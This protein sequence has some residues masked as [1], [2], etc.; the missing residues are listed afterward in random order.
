MFSEKLLHRFSL[1][2]TRPIDIKPDGIALQPSIE[3]P[4]HLE[5]SLPITFACLNH[6][7]ATQ[8]RGHPSR[9]VQPQ[10]MLACG[11]NAQALPPFSPTPTQSRMQAKARLV[12]ENYRLPLSQRLKFFLKAYGISGPP[13]FSLAD[14]CNR[15]ASADIPGDA[16]TSG[17]AL[18]LRLSRSAA[19]SGSPKSAHPIALDSAQSLAATSPGAPQW[20]SA[21]WPLNQWACQASASVVKPANPLDSPHGS[22]GSNSSAL[23]PRLPLS[24]LDADPLRPRATRLSLFLPKPQGF[25]RPTLKD[26]LSSPQ[27]ESK[28]K[29]GSSCNQ[30]SIVVAI[31]NFI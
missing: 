25:P 1:M 3:M 30:H 22:S 16:S 11:G 14:K 8:Q 15:L 28:S 9:N 18:L 13:R 21:P 5:E 29:K 10:P 26:V 19:L 23:G 20:F 4:K 27:R 31:C 7:V 24:I 17:P 12:L 2:P 6:A